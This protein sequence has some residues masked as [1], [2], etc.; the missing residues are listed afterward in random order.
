MSNPYPVQPSIEKMK[1]DA[2]RQK[3]NSGTQEKRELAG[4]GDFQ[5]KHLDNVAHNPNALLENPLQVRPVLPRRRARRVGRAVLVRSRPT[6]S[7][8]SPSRAPPADALTR[9]R[10]GISHERLEGES[11]RTFSHF[12]PAV[13]PLSDRRLG[14]ARAAEQHGSTLTP[15]T[16]QPWV[17]PLRARRAS[18]STRRSSPRVRALP[19]LVVP[20]SREPHA[21]AHSLAGAQVAQD[22]L[23]FESL[24]MLNDEDRNVLR[25]EIVRPSPTSSRPGEPL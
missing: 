15:C 14:S 11:S 5:D 6:A 2:A 19:P 16:V 25:R 23:A 20:P 4:E 9:G 12:E 17:V 8:S 21:D 1:E 24:T 13:P 10:Q 3:G 18:A 7:S 22:P